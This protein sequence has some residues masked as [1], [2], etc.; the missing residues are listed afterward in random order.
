MPQL[1]AAAQ[2]VG[3]VLGDIKTAANNVNAAALSLDANGALRTAI[4]R[5]PPTL[6]AARQ[7]L[8]GDQAAQFSNDVRAAIRSFTETMN[9]LSTVI[10]STGADF[11]DVA[12]SL[13]DASEHLEEFARSVRENPSLLLRTPKEE[14]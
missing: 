8:G 4:E 11:K 10:G 3:P 14:E 12:S 2:N 5:I 6:D 1:T 13:R 7:L 9:Q